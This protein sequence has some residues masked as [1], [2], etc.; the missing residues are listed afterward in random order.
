[1]ISQLR[2]RPVAIT[3]DVVVLDVAGVGYGVHAT[4]GARQ[5]AARAD[6]EVTIVTHLNVREDAL[7]LFGFAGTSER[8][9]FARLT[10][11]QGVGPKVALAIIST[12]DV[13]DLHAAVLAGDGT[14]LQAVPGVGPKVARRVVTELAGK[15]DD[16]VGEPLTARV[17][18]AGAAPAAD[19][20]LAALVSLGIQPSEAHAALAAGDSEAPV[21]ERIRAALRQVG[22]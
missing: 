12:L 15:L 13:A 19:D 8:E 9:L 10:A 22:A 3:D 1:M 18:E 14:P 17:A 2:G 4:A 11:L 7:Q 5:L 20:A 21:E 16:L 6:G